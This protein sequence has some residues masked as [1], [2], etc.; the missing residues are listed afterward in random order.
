MFYLT[1]IVISLVAGYLYRDLIDRIKELQKKLPKDNEIGAT[2]AS[3]GSIKGYSDN[4][5]GVGLVNPKTPE[6]LEWE[7]RQEEQ[8][9]GND[10]QR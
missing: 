3:Y 8:S 4:N 9:Y 6:Q 5:S 7:A 10:N 2:P 1:T